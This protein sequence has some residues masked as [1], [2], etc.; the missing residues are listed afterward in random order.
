MSEQD[1][2]ENIEV[3]EDLVNIKDLALG[4]AICSVTS[5]GGYLVAPEGQQP[6]IFGLIGAVLG[7]MIS[8][9]MIQ[10]KRNFTYIDEE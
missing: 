8:T 5:L 3:W 2:K 4:L 9:I 10:P 1:K 6:L 7:F